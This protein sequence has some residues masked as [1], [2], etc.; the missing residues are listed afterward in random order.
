MN[1]GESVTGCVFGRLAGWIE[2]ICTT[3]FLLTQI[4]VAKWVCVDAR[5]L[6][7]CRAAVTDANH[8]S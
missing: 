2:F 1:S 8:D 6:L 5:V 3:R 4:V 7:R